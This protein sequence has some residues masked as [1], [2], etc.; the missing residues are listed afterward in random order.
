MS[1]IRERWNAGGKQKWEGADK[2]G[3]WREHWMD[4][5][6]AGGGGG[7][8]GRGGSIGMG[9]EGGQKKEEGLKKSLTYLRQRQKRF[10]YF[11]PRS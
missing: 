1:W 6:S 10:L 11:P 5:E 2:L 4:G 3:G 9:W 7:G 8:G